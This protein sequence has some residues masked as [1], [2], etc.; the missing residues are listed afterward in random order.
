MEVGMEAVD[1]AVDANCNTRQR[2]AVN[3]ACDSSGDDVSGTPRDAGAHVP[4]VGAVLVGRVAQPQ[5]VHHLPTV[6]KVA[7]LV[8]AT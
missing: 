5:L 1:G 7:R 4:N 3:E 2:H 6:V 8:P